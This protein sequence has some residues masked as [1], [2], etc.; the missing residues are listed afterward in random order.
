V[1]RVGGRLDGGRTLQPAFQ[2]LR[3][4]SDKFAPGVPVVVYLDG[5]WPYYDDLTDDERRD[6]WRIYAAEAYANGLF[7]AFRLTAP[8]DQMH[9]PKTATTAN[10]FDLMQDLAKFYRLNKDLYHGVA[11]VPAAA[12]AVTTSSR[13]GSVMVAVSDWDGD[14]APGRLVHLV[15]HNYDVG[16]IRQDDVTVEIP[17]TAPVTSVRLVS[18]DVAQSVQLTPVV[19]PGD[20]GRI[21]VILP[22][23]LAY[24]VIVV[25]Y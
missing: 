25:S 10:V 2:S 19:L 23:L 22:S 7:F 9:D 13:P 15:N 17:V 11:P 14:H 18:P 16:L 24:D 6:Y 4:Q 20:G 3:A 21:S 1:P 12:S 5:L 8:H